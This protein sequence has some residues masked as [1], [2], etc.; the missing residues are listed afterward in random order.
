[1]QQTGG[2][3][4]ANQLVREGVKHV[5]GVP[6]VQ[7]DWAVD[8]LRKVADRIRY[9]VPRH[10]QATSYM[11]DGYARTSRSAGVCMVV[12][13]PGLLNAM[14]GLSTA[15]ACSSRVVCIS[16]DIHSSAINKGLGLLHEIRNQSFILGSVT[17][18]H[19]RADRPV[20][21]PNIVRSAFDALETG[22][23]QP[24]GLEIPHDVL[25]TSAEIDCVDPA[26]AERACVDKLQ[27]EQAAALLTAAKFPI[28]YVGGGVL[29]GRAS[30]ALI[31][32]AE[33]LQIPIVMGENGRGSISDRHPLALNTLDGRAVFPHADVVVVVGSRFV[34]TALGKPSWPADGKA[35]VFINLDPDVFGP[36]RTCSVA[37]KADCA[38]ALRALEQACPKR[39][40]ISVDLDKVRHWAR[41]QMDEIEPQGAWVR[42]LR[43]GIPDDGILVNELTQ[44][45]YFARLGYPVYAPGT[46]ITPGYQG[47]LGYGFPTALGAAVANPDRVV[48]SINGDGGFGWNIQELATARKYDLNATIVIF[49]D[50]HFGNV[51]K[52]QQDQFGREFGVELLNPKYDR[53]AEAFEIPYERADDPQQLLT[54][55][56]RRAG[57]RGPLV[58]EARVA[59][60]PSP[61]HLLRLVPPPFASDRKAPDAATVINAK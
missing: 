25:S 5:F 45:G 57:E 33:K 36:P 27:I 47:T 60:M 23:P 59:P 58:V 4:L 44:V 12:P 38:A 29:A 50:G 56:K 31:S 2:D 11:A 30:E 14:A 16:G 17:K 21:V 22:R 43:E 42:A 61:W 26:P 52:M 3:A 1:M 53:L 35:Y 18:W 40:P 15:Y 7:L 10:E 9:I 6:G 51:R 20:D 24:V 41:G 13:G 55:L 19:G 49:N 48:V 46:F 32:F 37:I 54:L 28:L 34:D 8:G 39:R